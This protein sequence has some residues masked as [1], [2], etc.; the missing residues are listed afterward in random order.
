[1]TRGARA[2]EPIRSLFLARSKRPG[3]S[4]QPSRTVFSRPRS[5]IERDQPR[6][7]WPG[8]GDADRIVGWSR[9]DETG[10]GEQCRSRTLLPMARHHLIGG[11]E[12]RPPLRVTSL[13]LLDNSQVRL[14]LVPALGEL[15]LGLFVRQRRNDDNVV[16]VFPVRGRRHLVLRGKLQ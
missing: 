3:A 1:M 15:G 12:R 13:G 4:M 11:G 10:P 5:V 14:L 2:F 6:T 8:G 9:P 7:R 16:S